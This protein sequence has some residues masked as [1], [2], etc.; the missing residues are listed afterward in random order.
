MPM[1]RLL[2]LPVVLALAACGGSDLPDPIP[3]TCGYTAS[4]GPLT[5]NPPL[6][7]TCGTVVSP[8]VNVYTFTAASSAQHTVTLVTTAGDADLC[9]ASGSLIIACSATVPPYPD[10]VSFVAAA[11]TPYE[12]Q[13]ED[14]SFTGP[15]SSYGVVVTSP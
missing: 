14:L 13:V 3:V 8:A 7:Y 15:S 5:V 1:T 11:G 6:G 12:V 10:V 2:P 4:S 9:L